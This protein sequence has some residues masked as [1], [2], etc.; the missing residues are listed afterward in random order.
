MYRWLQYVWHL[1]YLYRPHVALG[2]CLPTTCGTRPAFAGHMW[3]WFC[4]CLPHVALGLSLSATCGIR[5]VSGCHMWH[6]ARLCRLYVALVLFIAGHNT[7]PMWNFFCLHW[8]HVE[9]DLFTLTAMTCVS[10]YTVQ[11]VSC[12]CFIGYLIIFCL[13]QTGQYRRPEHD[14]DDYFTIATRERTISFNHSSWISLIL[15]P[16]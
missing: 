9:L 1:F 10:V 3:H 8:P 6:S 2:L 14:K 7:M 12:K 13:S 4:L 15:L 5:L 11:W 16:E